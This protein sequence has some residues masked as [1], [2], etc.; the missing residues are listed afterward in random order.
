MAQTQI[1]EIN[2]DGRLLRHYR[3]FL[4][5]EHNGSEIGRIPWAD[6]SAILLTAPDSLISKYTLMTASEHNIPILV[7]G[8]NYHPI[9]ILSS[10]HDHGE[11]K[12]VLELQI[13]APAPHL[14]NLWKS[15]ISKKI[16]GQAHIL[17]HYS[18]NPDSANYLY[19]LAKS[20]LS[21]D[22]KNNESIAAAHYWKNLFNTPFKRLGQHGT[23]FNALLNYAYAIMRATLARNIIASGLNPSLGIHH[24]NKRNP[25]CLVD[26]LIEVFRPIID[27]FLLTNLHQL[28]FDLTPADKKILAT[29][30]TLSVLN[31][32]GEYSTITQTSCELAQSF[33][34]ALKSKKAELYF[35]NFLPV[36]N[37]I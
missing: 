28:T 23:E 20:V 14:K 37:K 10:L 34:R 18:A 1:V 36:T 15:I 7:M 8:K 24:I 31:H 17:K 13:S 32:A 4:L 21:G 3:G 29:I 33:V 2:A 19:P 27:G 30:P 35:P 22:S 26:D 9:G 16:S 12:S 25:F 5:I 6:I 11:S